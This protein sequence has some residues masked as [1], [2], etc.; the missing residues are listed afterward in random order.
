MY[1]ALIFKE[2]IKIR[3]IFLGGIILSLAIAIGFILDLHQGFVHRKAAFIWHTTVVKHDIFYDILNYAGALCGVVIGMA[4][5]I[6]EVTKNRIRLSLHLPVNTEKL[7]LLMQGIGLLAI[8]LL[9]AFNALLATLI[10]AYYFPWIMTRSMLYTLL[11]WFIAA[12]P[13]Y[14]GVALVAFEPKMIRQVLYSIFIFIIVMTFTN[15]WYYQLYD[16]SLPRYLALTLLFSGT[17]FLPV[18]RFRK[19]IQ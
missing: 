18:Y 4:Q 2:W 9:L 8:T 10:S 15:N 5:F 13:A 11:P 19:G 16:N 14:L 17:I 6:P 7:L 1:Q 3:K 12:I